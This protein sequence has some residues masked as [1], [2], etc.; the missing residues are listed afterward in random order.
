MNRGKQAILNT[1]TKKRSEQIWVLQR[2]IPKCSGRK[3]TKRRTNSMKRCIKPGF[4]WFTT[5]YHQKSSFRSAPIFIP[6]LAQGLLHL[7][8]ETC[9]DRHC[10][11]G[12]SECWKLRI[13]LELFII[14][15]IV[16]RR[17]GARGLLFQ[18]YPPVSRIG[19]S[20]IRHLRMHSL[21][22]TDA[23]VEGHAYKLSVHSPSTGIWVRTL[24]PDPKTAT[25]LRVAQ[26]RI[27]R[28]ML[29]VTLRIEIRNEDLRRLTIVKML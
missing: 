11:Q 25:K 22:N 27:K 2:L 18:S 28:A 10:N 21:R 14:K 6:V 8:S 15:E 23:S 1:T 5:D 9:F 4:W 29:G 7:F 12:S 26:R 24:T 19:I 20:T 13:Y 17:V 3:D 16:A